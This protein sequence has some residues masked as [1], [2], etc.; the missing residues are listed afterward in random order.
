MIKHVVLQPKQT[1][2]TLFLRQETEQ[3]HRKTEN[4][5]IMRSVMGEEFLTAAYQALL[6]RMLSFYSPVEQN[7][8]TFESKTD[9]TYHYQ[10]KHLLLREDLT[11]L[12]SQTTSKEVKGSDIPAV[13]TI[14]DFLGVLYVLEGS[15]LGGA[16]IH[17]ALDKHINASKA[18]TF[19]YPYGKET[20]KRWNETRAF[21]DDYGEKEY[22]NHNKVCDAAIATFKSIGGALNDESI[23]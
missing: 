8:V 11:H 15:T 13:E 12:C 18:A 19:F 16:L 2:L 23:T 10:S 4:S 21:I 17:K 3:E 1:P 22:I 9:L 7:I 6:K 20:K 14:E 5:A